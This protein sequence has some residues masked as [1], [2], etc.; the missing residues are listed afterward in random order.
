MATCPSDK[1]TK[2]VYP[3]GSIGI[4]AS[5]VTKTYGKIDG[6]ASKLKYPS[7]AAEFADVWSIQYNCR[8][9]YFLRDLSTSK[10][11]YKRIY[12]YHQ[13]NR[14]NLVH[15]DGHYVNY[16]ITELPYTSTA[17]GYF[18]FWCGVDN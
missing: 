6:K 15:A 10:E 13:G 3:Y 7:E 17:S 14:V 16:K 5:L 18:H 2:A 11:T 1:Y 9:F 4:N 8:T 12:P